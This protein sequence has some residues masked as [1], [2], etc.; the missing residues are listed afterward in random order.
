MRA[1]N[2]MV[3]G[4]DMDVNFERCYMESSRLIHFSLGWVRITS[5]IRPG[6]AIDQVHEKLRWP[7]VSLSIRRTDRMC[8]KHGIGFVQ[9]QLRGYSLPAK[10][11]RRAAADCATQ[12]QCANVGPALDP[13]RRAPPRPRGTEPPFPPALAA[14]SPASADGAEAAFPGRRRCPRRQA[15]D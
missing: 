2:I 15:G 14:E 4:Q 13:T 3:K 8:S 6:C 9:L 12:R 1:G 10:R 5:S 7:L 11:T